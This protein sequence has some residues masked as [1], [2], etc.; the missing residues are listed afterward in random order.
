MHVIDGWRWLGTATDEATLADI[1][2]TGR[3]AFDL[4]IYKI[5]VK[6]VKRLPVVRL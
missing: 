1:L 3:P 5:L 2:D 4:D 6:A